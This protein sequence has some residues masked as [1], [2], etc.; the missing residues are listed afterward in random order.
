M[1]VLMLTYIHIHSQCG[2]EEEE[3]Q[4]VDV[5]R[6]ISIS[7]CQL[8]L[9]Q[10]AARLVACSTFINFLMQR[11]PTKSSPH[12]HTH[13]HTHLHPPPSF[14]SSLFLERVLLAFISSCRAAASVAS[15]PPSPA[16]PPPPPF[17]VC[18]LQFLWHFRWLF[19]SSLGHMQM[20]QMLGL[21]LLR[22]PLALLAVRKVLQINYILLGCYPAPSPPPP[23]PIQESLPAPVASPAH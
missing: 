5:V 23:P 3:E 12:T 15:A 8:Q 11:R 1:S 16:P 9:P 13:I 18:L 19:G 7:L 2:T 14:Y 4:L 17:T 20:L 10:I 21:H 6:V 22:L